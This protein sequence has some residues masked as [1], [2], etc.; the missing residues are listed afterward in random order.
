M[1][2]DGVS[3]FTGKTYAHMNETADRARKQGKELGG[4][5]VVSFGNKKQKNDFDALQTEKK[6]AVRVLLDHYASGEYSLTTPEGQKA[7]NKLAGKE[8]NRLIAHS[9]GASIT[10]ALIRKDLI[11][12]DE[13][14]IVG[15]DKS[16]INAPAYQELLDS[17]KVKRVVVWVNVNDPVPAMTSAD[18][19]IVAGT[20]VDAAMHVAKK[21]VG[22]TDVE[23]RFMWGAD[24]R[25]PAGGD[26]NAALSSHFIESSYFP[27]MANEL[28]VTY[29]PPKRIIEEKKKKK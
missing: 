11:K 17:G 2:E 8:F 6:E 16:L 18:P 13:L 21:I 24:Y 23:Y 27:G 5:M 15:G 14:N 12:V 28:G 20:S 3:C 26:V 29:V 25:N 19:L 4:A 10:E 22:K 7:V 1:E 9:N